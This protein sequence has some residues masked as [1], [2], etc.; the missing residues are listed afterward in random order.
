MTPGNPPTTWIWLRHAPVVGGQGLTGRRDPVIATPDPGALAA[1]VNALP[2]VSAVSAS[3]A[4][5]CVET[6]AALRAAGVRLPAESLCPAFWEQ[7]FGAWEG[8]DP[9]ACDWPRQ[10]DLTTMAAFVPPDGESFVTLC[11]RVRAEIGRVN[12]AHPGETIAV[13]AHAGTIRAALVAALG[14][15]PGAGLAF[16]VRPLSLTRLTAFGDQGWRVDAVNV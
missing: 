16:D 2:P 1:C 15:D 10:A 14:C 7:D 13:C 12:A 9:A 3:P 4:R 11:A 5:R 6:L 8:R